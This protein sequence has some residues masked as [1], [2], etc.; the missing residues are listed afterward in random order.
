M[1]EQATPSRSEE[2]EFLDALKGMLKPEERIQRLREVYEGDPEFYRRI[3]KHA[4]IGAW[5]WIELPDED[6]R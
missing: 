1:G 6:R 2:G 4:E 5:A 3:K